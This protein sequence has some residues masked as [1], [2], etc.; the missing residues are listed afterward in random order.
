[1][2]RFCNTLNWEDERFQGV[3]FL[4]HLETENIGGRRY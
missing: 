3:A 4:Q 1:V 2:L